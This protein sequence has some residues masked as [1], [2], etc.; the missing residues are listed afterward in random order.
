[1][2]EIP[3]SITSPW[4]VILVADE[5]KSTSGGTGFYIEERS[6]YMNMISIFLNQL[7]IIYFTVHKFMFENLLYYLGNKVLFVQAER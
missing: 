3:Q 2:V 7:N 1:M 5:T 6:L 4:Q